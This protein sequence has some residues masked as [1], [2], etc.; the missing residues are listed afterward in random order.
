MPVTLLA[1]FGRLLRI[2]NRPIGDILQGVIVD[3]ISKKCPLPFA[4]ANRIAGV[5][6]PAAKAAT[7]RQ[8]LHPEGARE[9]LEM[10]S[11]LLEIMR[12]ADLVPVIERERPA[13][14]RSQK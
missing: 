12:Q 9:I 8:C 10:E 4:C 6:H 13:G 2:L 1:G 7:G 11:S 5:M 3:D 14:W